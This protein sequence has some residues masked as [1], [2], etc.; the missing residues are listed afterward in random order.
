MVMTGICMLKGDSPVQGTT[1]F[2]QKASSSEPVVVSGQITGWTEGEHGF[3]AHQFGD[4][5]QDCTSA[6][7]HFNP[8]SK[9]HGGPVGQERHVGDLGKHDRPVGQKRHVRGLGNVTAGKEGVVNVSP[10]GCVITLSGEQSIIG[11][12]MVVHEKQDDLGKGG[13]NEST[14]TENAR[15]CSWLVV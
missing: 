3:H 15:S 9:K 10:E 6:G 11:H 4:N 8:H 13:N 12:T 1:H 5:T 7:P 14:K 2:E